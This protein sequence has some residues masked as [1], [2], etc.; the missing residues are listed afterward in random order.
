MRHPLMLIFDGLGLVLTLMMLAR[1]GRT[2]FR[3]WLKAAWIAFMVLFCVRACFRFVSLGT[4]G[5]VITCIFVV[6][7]AIGVWH[8]TVHNG[9]SAWWAKL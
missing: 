9:W 2:A 1:V 7:M 8:N 3:D 4:S 6:G 5:I